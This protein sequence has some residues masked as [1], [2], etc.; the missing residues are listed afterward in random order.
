MAAIT[1]LTGMWVTA[2]R[3]RSSRRFVRGGEDVGLA[4]VELAGDASD[5]PVAG[6]GCHVALERADDDSAIRLGAVHSFRVC[7]VAADPRQD[8]VG[9]LHGAVELLGFDRDGLL[10]EQGHGGAA[11]RFSGVWRCRWWR[12]C[13]GR[14]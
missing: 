9:R 7:T 11:L 3:G 10:A 2:S 13:C 4:G 6:D 1:S 12:G 14:S 5:D 8:A